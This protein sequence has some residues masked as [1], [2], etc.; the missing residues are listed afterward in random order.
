MSNASGAADEGIAEGGQCM[1]TGALSADATVT[2]TCCLPSV[3]AGG[4]W[5]PAQPTSG[6]KK[7]FAPRFCASVSP[8]AAR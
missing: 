7:I 4:G 5:Q 6:R 1:V 2:T 3:H 8:A